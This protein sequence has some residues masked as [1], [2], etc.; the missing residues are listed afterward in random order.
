MNGK[1]RQI[2]IIG[3]GAAAFACALRAAEDGARV[4]L[5][6]SGTLGGT[7]VNVGCIPSK[8]LIRDAARIPPATH[9]V[10]GV[11]QQIHV[12]GRALLEH[13]SDLVSRMRQRKYADVLAAS[14]NIRRLSGHARF[15][16]EHTLHIERTDGHTRTVRP[17][18][19]LI[20]TGARPNVPDLPGLAGTPFW[21]SN[22]ALASPEIPQHLLIVGGST[23]AVELAQAYR[24]LGAAVTIV[25]RSA[26]LPREDRDIGAA[27]TRI[28]RN[29]GIAVREGTAALSVA[30]S[31]NEFQ[32]Q[33]PQ[34]ILRGDRLLIAAGRRANTS[35]L[36][37]ANT[38]VE[39]DA[40][41]RIR[42]DARMRTNCAHIFAAGDCTTLP[43]YVYVAAAAGKRAAI[44]MLGGE[45]RL[46]LDTL[47][48]VTFLDPQVASVGLTEHAAREQRLNVEARLLPA[49]EIPRAS[50]NGD[51]RGFIKLVAERG[52]GRLLGA[53]IIADQAGEIIQAAA[54]AMRAGFTIQD[55]ADEMIPYLTMAEGVKLC[56]QT[57]MQDLTRLSCCAG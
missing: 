53:H 25:A 51:H 16:D 26:L 5:V 49:S 55:L 21:T 30:H 6:E 48:S 40:E 3:S 18:C 54:L 4:T 45:A 20:A 32:L 43:Q 46:D 39:T 33:T 37:L 2:T 56:A 14:A 24:R 10:R 29:D 7:C 52:S 41:D 23:V 47:A 57:F 42:V 50:V 31:G 15:H 13:R 17:E 11:Q 38:G 28:F 22:E 27:L 44:N 1:P 9:H 34:E 8:A 12:N 35:A 36:N 19:I